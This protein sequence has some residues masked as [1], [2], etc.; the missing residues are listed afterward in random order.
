MN[1]WKVNEKLY[2]CIHK[3][4]LKTH[5]I[6][7]DDHLPVLAAQQTSNLVRLIHMAAYSHPQRPRTNPPELFHTS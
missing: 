1:L 3:L 4:Q 6:P 2:D 5:E 7:T